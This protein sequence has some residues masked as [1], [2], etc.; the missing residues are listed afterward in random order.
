MK[1]NMEKILVDQINKLQESVDNIGNEIAQQHYT[2]EQK[3]KELEKTTRRLTYVRKKSEDLTPGSIIINVENGRQMVV[4]EVNPQELTF[5]AQYPNDTE[6]KDHT[7]DYIGSTWRAS[8]DA[9]QMEVIINCICGNSTKLKSKP[10][11]DFRGAY[12]TIG[13]L[14]GDQ[15][16]IF[17]YS[18]AEVS[19]TC[20]KCNRTLT[21]V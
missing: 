12:N 10:E 8:P 14:E 16:G 7:F 1:E 21:I 11:E 3:K 5:I 20:K 4:V 2:L 18:D 17:A 13:W 6:E 19:V 9:V 15:F